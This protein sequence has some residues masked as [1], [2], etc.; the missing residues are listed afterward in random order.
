[1][2]WGNLNFK[3]RGWKKVFQEKTWFQKEKIWFLDSGI[4]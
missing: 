3:F 1:M 2:P 4:I